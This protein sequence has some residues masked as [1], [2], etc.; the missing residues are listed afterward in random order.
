MEYHI[1]LSAIEESRR[2]QLDQIE[3]LLSEMTNNDYEDKQEKNKIL[4]LLADALLQCDNCIGTADSYHNVAVAYAREDAEDIACKILEKGLKQFPHSVDLL[5]DYI[6]YIISCTDFN[7]ALPKYDKLATIPKNRWNWRAF[8]FSI[9]YLF[10]RVEREELDEEAI[11]SIIETICKLVEEYKKYLPYD[12]KA[13]LAEA[14]MQR[15]FNEH[16]KE[17]AT[18]KS[19]IEQLKAAPKCLIRLADIQYERGDYAAALKLIDRC[20]RDAIEPQLGVNYGYTFYLSALCKI[21]TLFECINELGGGATDAMK[22]QIE[23]IFEDCR[24]ALRIL[25]IIRYK[26]NITMLTKVIEVKSGVDFID[27]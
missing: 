8:T 11:E 25:K 17:R 4:L 10:A 5:A 13:F 24:V 12:E 16:D 21:A 19:A 9:D 15:Q 7:N 2:C 27:E 22:A 1:V 18:L 26:K 14:E 23:D 3:Q 20:K 6:K